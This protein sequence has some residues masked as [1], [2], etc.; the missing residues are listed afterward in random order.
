MR[1]LHNKK[2]NKALYYQLLL[3]F[4]FGKTNGLSVN[5]LLKFLERR[6]GFSWNFGLFSENI[7]GSPSLVFQYHSKVSAVKK[8]Y[9]SF[10]NL[11]WEIH[12][13]DE[14][15]WFYLFWECF[16]AC[17]LDTD[18][19]KLMAS[20]GVTFYQGLSQLQISIP[21]FVLKFRFWESE[22]ITPTTPSTRCMKKL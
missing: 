21:C 20:S 19:R 3:F 16:L 5:L 11:R 15:G 9:L 8:E 12:L 7:L 18:H 14:T 6:E 22:S 10:W 13:A 1:L 17:K 2:I 4:I